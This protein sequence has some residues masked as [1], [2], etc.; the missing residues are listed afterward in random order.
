MTKITYRC[1]NCGGEFESGWSDD[2]A[3]AESVEN[4]GQRGDD[5]GMA[6]VCDDCFRDVMERIGAKRKGLM[7][8]PADR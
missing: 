6:I 8:K 5:P 2:E 4:F 3:Q 7:E 1:E